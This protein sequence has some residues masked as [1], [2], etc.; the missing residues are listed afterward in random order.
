VATSGGEFVTLLVTRV[1]EAQPLVDEHLRDN[2]D[3]LLHLLLADLARFCYA[4]H[5]RSDR[6]LVD[7]C[8][9][10][11]DRG[12]RQG[13]ESLTNA[14][15]LSFVENFSPWHPG[16]RTFSASWPPALLAE[17]RRQGAV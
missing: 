7:R 16:Q 1:P 12:L 15:A 3:L 9:A 2:D 5:Q 8:L 11:V 4:A 14:V 13:D 6:S 10:E 17:A